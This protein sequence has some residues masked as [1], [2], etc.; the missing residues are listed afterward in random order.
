VN[1]LAAARS[2]ECKMSPDLARVQVFTRYKVL[3]VKDA[4]KI[5]H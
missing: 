1:C 5:A 2:C 4:S 3:I